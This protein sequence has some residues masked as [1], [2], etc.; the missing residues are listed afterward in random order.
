MGNEILKSAGMAPVPIQHDDAPMLAMI[1]SALERGVTPDVLDKLL[2]VQQRWEADKARKAYNAALAA[3]KAECP[4]VIAKTGRVDFTS[5]KGRTNYAYTPLS[6]VLDTVTPL[7]AKHG[8]NL[9]WQTTQ[10]TPQNV[11][12][13]CCLRHA[14]GHCEETSL[15]GPVDLSGNKNPI[16]AIASTV[17][18][19]QRYTAIALLGLATA[20][21]DD[22]GNQGMRVHVNVNGE[23]AAPFEPRQATVQKPVPSPSTD[24]YEVFRGVVLDVKEKS[25]TTAK[26]KCWKKFGIVLAGCQDVLGTFS[27]SFAKFAADNLGKRVVVFCSRDKGKF[28]TVQQIEL[29]PDA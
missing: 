13:T 4:S 6:Q 10:P 21:I 18:Y 2:C 7:L 23:P 24:G 26:G 28:L 19:L 1:Q 3:F 14:M 20:E 12:V 16:Q 22:D 9:S 5:S 8:L 29:D 15:F 25:G 17:T 27:E 11:L